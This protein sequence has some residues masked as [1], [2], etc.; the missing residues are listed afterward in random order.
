MAEGGDRGWWRALI[1]AL[2][3]VAVLFAALNVRATSQDAADATARAAAGG[4]LAAAVDRMAPLERS[5]L[6]SRSR[7]RSDGLA[8]TRRQV[9][10][11]A[12]A[13]ERQHSGEGTAAG[14]E[15]Q[16][17]ATV[18][19]LGIATRSGHAGSAGRRRAE[20][21]LA[22]LQP[23]TRSLSDD[24]ATAAAA[25]DHRAGQRLILT[26][27][28]VLLLVALLLGTFW[29]RRSAADAERRERRFRALLRDSSDLVVVI[30]PVTFCIRYVTP[31]VERMLGY[32]PETVTGTP[33]PELANPDDRAALT[34]GLRATVDDVDSRPTGRWRA[35]HSAGGSV[36]VEA[37]WLDL[38]D[39]PSVK[40]LVVTV[41]DVGER[42][43]LEDQ[44]RHQ[45]FHDPLTALPNRLLF[46]N[47]VRHAVAGA[48]RHG[49]PIS[50][51]FVDLDDFKTVNDSLGHA[52]GD[53][54]LRKVAERLDGL[55]RGADTVARLGGDEF[56][57]L[58]EEAESPDE[59]RVISERIHAGMELPFDIEGHELFMHASV[60]IAK[61]ESGSTSEDLMR[62]ADTAMYA[63]KAGGKGR[64]EIF[65]PTMHMEVQRRL[66]LSGDL[67]RAL[68]HDEIFAQYQPLVDL[69]S[70]RV[71][72]A[73]A[74]ARWHHPTL[75]EIPPSDFI[76]VAEDT[77]LIVPLGG[78]ILNQACRQARIWQDQSPGDPVYV[79]VNVSPRQFRQAGA[80]VE[81]V[82]EA[83]EASGIEPS[84]LVLEITESVLMQDRKAVRNELS[85]LQELGVRV[86]IDDF[87][88]GYSALSYLRDFPIDMVRMDQSFVSDLSVGDGDQA[89][90]R[91]VVEL[92]E[93]LGMQIVAEGIE[94]REQRDHLSDM[95]CSIGQGFYFARP[96]DAERMYELVSTAHR[97]PRPGDAADQ[98]GG[99]TPEPA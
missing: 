20:R 24:L 69:E 82:R 66:Q 97:M 57:V 86:A 1:P 13:I 74:L 81:Q 73:E 15:E 59:G 79:S 47:R 61:S 7:P 95:R 91:S 83:T 17:N 89:L 32:R 76:P 63:A 92:G 21:L 78:R 41:R 3:V 50:V 22:G 16:A 99:A 12:A 2:A 6:A 98:M 33:F 55:V 5:A 56:A 36:D 75:G 8:V 42:T 94:H 25:A 58:V 85:Q 93:A 64:S 96:L 60:G 40:G 54:M 87:G 46:E 52:A 19:A 28:A 18:R 14:I 4:E 67:R 30:D 71:V 31:A 48:R 23:A 80:V 45:A 37:T 53:E 38:R 11:A 26:M 35:L 29:S 10:T 68:L 90:V 62:N 9:T 88:T 27:I 49:R 72:G 44:L 39:D 34:E 70:G 65:K 84:L 77:G 43:D 51:L